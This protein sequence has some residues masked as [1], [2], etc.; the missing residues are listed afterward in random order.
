MSDRS[1]ALGLGESLTPRWSTCTTGSCCFVL[2]VGEAGETDDDDV[3]EDSFDALLWGR[4]FLGDTVASD[5]EE[6]ELYDEDV[7]EVLD[8]PLESSDVVLEWDDV[9]LRRNAE[10]SSLI[11]SSSTVLPVSCPFMCIECA[12]LKEAT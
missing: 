11:P 5:V 8:E 3:D 4:T 1:C 10:R 9:L 2:F 7:D 12:A 6:D